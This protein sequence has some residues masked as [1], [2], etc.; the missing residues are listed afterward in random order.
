MKRRH[1]AFIFLTLTLMLLAACG[2]QS[3]ESDDSQSA[4]NEEEEV[5]ML[6]VDLTSNPESESIEP[7][8]PFTIQAAVT[9]GEE[10]VNDANEVKFEFWKKGEEHEKVDGE[11]TEN[12]IYTLEKTVEEP[13]IY[14]VISHV[15]A[16]G[17][18]NMPQIKLVVGDVD[19]EGAEE[20]SEDE[21]S[22]SEDGHDEDG[23][24]DSTE[25]AHGTNIMAHIML[26]ENVKSGEEVTLTGH[27]QHDEAPFKGAEVQFEIWKDGTD[28]HN[29]VEAT[30]PKDGEY[31]A[32]YTFDEAANY[33][34]K[35]HFKKEDLHDHKETTLTVQ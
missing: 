20:T 11:F 18:H 25:H 24:G 31:Q 33:H 4:S 26:P 27:L 8:E 30:E 23:H 2:S 12:G 9:Y 14:Y 1:F 29:Y 32:T 16:R 7:G 6:N 35:L 10:E 34:V 17:M 28:K 19:Q 22:H 15:T 5:K 3:N 13:G 21:H